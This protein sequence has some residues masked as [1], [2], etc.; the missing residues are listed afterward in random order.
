MWLSGIAY[1]I[2]RA[3][4][5]DYNDLPLQQQ[6]TV[7]LIPLVF[8]IALAIVLAYF[9]LTRIFDRLVAAVVALLLALDPYHITISK[10]LHVDGLM[11]IFMLLSALFIFL[12][13]TPAGLQRR[14]YL[15]LSGFFA[16]LALLSKTPALFMLPFFLLS[17]GAWKLTELLASGRSRASLSDWRFWTKTAGELGIA[18]LLWLLAMAAT[19]AILWPSMWI[20]PQDTIRLSLLETLRYGA[21]PHGKSLAWSLSSAAG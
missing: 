5:P 8:V 10:T 6:M 2:G 13:I 7:E 21:N 20:Q 19:F 1:R 17:L 9:L 11:A 18:I 4:N 3:F 12:Y 15:L 14:R 16:G